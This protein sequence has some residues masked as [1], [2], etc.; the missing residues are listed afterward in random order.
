[1]RKQ[2]TRQIDSAAQRVPMHKRAEVGALA[3]AAR[4]SLSTFQGAGLES[5]L[6][7]MSGRT[8]S[9]EEFLRDYVRMRP[10][11]LKSKTGPDDRSGFRLLVLLAGGSPK[12]RS[13]ARLS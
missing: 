1:M 3:D 7:E 13:G 9:A 6:M 11:S 8:S 4:D 10:P 12:L 2:I 5:Q